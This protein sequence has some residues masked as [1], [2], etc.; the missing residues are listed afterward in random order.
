MARGISKQM[1]E[2]MERERDRKAISDSKSVITHWGDFVV[3]NN[4][5]CCVSGLLV[6]TK[7][8]KQADKRS[9]LS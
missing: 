2:E 6:R 1:F 9:L 8:P 5:Y 4:N 7:E 3:D